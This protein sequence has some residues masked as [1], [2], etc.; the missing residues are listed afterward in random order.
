MSSM[1][2][3]GALAPTSAMKAAAQNLPAQMVFWQLLVVKAGLTPTVSTV[4]INAL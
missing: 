4:L 2:V 1:Q 3:E